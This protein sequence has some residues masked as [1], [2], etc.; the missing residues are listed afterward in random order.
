MVTS[1]AAL[2]VPP[3]VP[4]PDWGWLTPGVSLLQHFDAIEVLHLDNAHRSDLV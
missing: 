2:A 3:P 1:A 4:A